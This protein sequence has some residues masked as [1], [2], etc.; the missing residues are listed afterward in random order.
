MYTCSV[1]SGNQR[2][3]F[4]WKKDDMVLRKTD[5]LN[6]ETSLSHSVLSISN[7]DEYD[8]GNY[9]CLVKNNEGSDSYVLPLIVKG[10]FLKNTIKFN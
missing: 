3:S 10:N 9:T 4:E 6:I 2:L 7:I 1:I 8:A 5:K